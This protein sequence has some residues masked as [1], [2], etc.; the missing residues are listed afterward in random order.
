[1]SAPALLACGAA[2]LCLGLPLIAASAQLEA[3]H[4]AAAAADA[5]ALAAADAMTGWI[6]GEP[7]ALAGL[8]AVEAGAALAGC[9]ASSVSGEARVEMRIALPF[10]DAVAAARAGPPPGPVQ[11]ARGAVAANGWAWPSDLR[12][13]SQGFHD[14]FSLDL[15][16]TAEGALYAPYA[17]VVVRAGPDGGGMP[18]PCVARPEW[19]RGVNHTVLMRHDVGGRTLYSSHNHVA[20]GSPQ[21][22]GV[23][24]GARV[25]AGQRVASAGMSGCTS[26]PHTHFTLSSAPSNRNPDV[27]PLAYLGPP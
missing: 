15:E 13:L 21:R 26:G 7:C 1:M 18:D 19:W 3:G 11:A 2:A 6:E 25:V 12:A 23:V 14:G 20:P 8:V 4:R 24:P 9:E 22:F 10:G 5:A 17:G 27:D 16:V